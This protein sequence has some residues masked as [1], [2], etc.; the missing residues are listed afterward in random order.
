MENA[1]QTVAFSPFFLYLY[2]ITHNYSTRTYIHLLLVNSKIP[3][4]YFSLYWSCNSHRF[5]YKYEQIWMIW[6]F[7]TWWSFG[8]TSLWHFLFKFLLRPWFCNK[9]VTH[10]SAAH[11]GFVYTRRCRR[12]TR[13]AL[14]FYFFSEE[15][16]GGGWGGW[17]TLLIY[18][19]NKRKGKDEQGNRL[20]GGTRKSERRSDSP[21]PVKRAVSQR[22]SPNQTES[23]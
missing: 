20:Y 6:C 10:T 12:W 8:R 4:G 11:H 14:P 17:R 23:R 15:G 19:L 3:T 21:T 1:N 16:R 18:C 22:T 7:C 13:V 5:S 9:D 2:I